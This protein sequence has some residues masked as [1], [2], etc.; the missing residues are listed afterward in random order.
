MWSPVLN[1]ALAVVSPAGSIDGRA[2]FSLHYGYHAITTMIAYGCAAGAATL[3]AVGVSIVRQTVDEGGAVPREN[4]TVRRADWQC[5]SAA[6]RVVIVA[7]IAVLVAGLAAAAYK[8]QQHI[9]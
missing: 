8:T 9:S 1:D 6:T 5:Q 7:S 4:R 3:H 2:A